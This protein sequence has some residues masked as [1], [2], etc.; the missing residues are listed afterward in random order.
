MIESI[1]KSLHLRYASILNQARLNTIMN[2]QMFLTA[3]EEPL[4]DYE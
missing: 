2:S 1:S 4:A 3:T